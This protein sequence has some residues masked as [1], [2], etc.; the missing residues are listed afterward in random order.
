MLQLLT[1]RVLSIK[2]CTQCINLYT[3]RM[4]F[5]FWL[6]HPLPAAWVKCLC[7]TA[8]QGTRGD[9]VLP[10]A[11]ALRERGAP[12]P[13]RHGNAAQPPATTPKTL[14][15]LHIRHATRSEKQQS[16]HPFL[17]LFAHPCVHPSVH[18]SIHL[19]VHPSFIHPFMHS[20]T[21]P[22]HP[23]VCPFI[24]PSVCLQHVVA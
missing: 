24:H 20:P 10:L 9:P 14:T 19:S 7:V 4:L 23:I 18:A 3:H 8:T 13:I 11:E 1:T 5:V 12:P 17:C 2:L 6:S 15:G 22:S 21:H 16:N